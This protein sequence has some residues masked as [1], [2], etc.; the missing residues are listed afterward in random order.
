MYVCSLSPSERLDQRGS[1]YFRKPLGAVG[2]SKTKNQKKGH[3]EMSEKN[4]A[5]PQNILKFNFADEIGITIKK[6]T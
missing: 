4:S 6:C 2:Q 5:N 1:N 3:N